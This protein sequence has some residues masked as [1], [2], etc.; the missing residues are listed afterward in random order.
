MAVV[1][2][3]PAESG[4]CARDAGRWESEAL[5]GW[6]YLCRAVAMARIF[7]AVRVAEWVG[8]LSMSGGT[9]VGCCDLRDAQ[10]WV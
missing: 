9:E 1:R 7:S 3:Q 10:D 2:C 8:G 5:V 4:P 6:R